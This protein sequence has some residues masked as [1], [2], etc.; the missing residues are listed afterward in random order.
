MKKLLSILCAVLAAIA[1]F[2]FAGCG[3]KHNAVLYSYANDWI[4]EDFLN[5]NRV[6]GYYVN[7]D[8]IE[9]MSDWDTRYIYDSNSPSERTFIITGEEEF[10][11]IFTKC[12]V[13]V[14]F[15]KKMVILY[16]FSDCYPKTR[17][18]NLEKIKSENRKL[19]INYKL[20]NN[21]RN[22]AVMLYQR[23]FMVVLDILDITDVEFIDV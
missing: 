17:I 22:D 13:E 10:N 7:E 12:T 9:G 3:N 8:Y 2:S 11:H 14:D 6:K 15:S 18:Y 21:K 19:E 1:L 4:D 16:I 23:C 20:E 5:E